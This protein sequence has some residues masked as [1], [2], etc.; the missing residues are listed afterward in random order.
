MWLKKH[1]EQHDYPPFHLLN[2]AGW[3]LILLADTFI[4]SPHLLLNNLPVLVMNS[5][6]WFSGYCISLY[7]RSIYLKYNYSS[8]SIYK[9]ISFVLIVSFLS[10]LLLFFV[11]HL[12][13]VPYNLN[14]LNKFIDYVFTIRV[15]ANNLTRFLPL[16]TTWSLLYFGLKFWIDLQTIRNRA[17]KSDLLA[18]SAQLQML[19]Y[20][21]NPHFLFNSFSSLRALIR[22][23]SS[24]AEEMLT[25]L[26]D[27]YRYTLITRNSNF[28]PLKDE[29]E[30]IKHYA[31]IEKIRFE[32]RI[33][34][35]FA[36]HENAK[37]IFVP[38]FI[39]HPLIENAVKHGK[40]EKGKPLVINVKSALVDDWLVL[41]VENTGTWSARETT[42]PKSGTG[43]GISN[44]LKRLENSYGSSFSF[45]TYDEDDMAKVELKIKRAKN[46]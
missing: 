8:Q 35:N 44:L 26:S 20:Q 29:I 10:S 25:Q 42:K 1:I 2:A 17:E 38:T 18:Q 15:I 33:E 43:T 27:F 46:E 6:Q 23:N 34:F 4:V 7:M 3:I 31:A 39:I 16:L 9:V 28:V 14:N 19:R 11:V 13:A 32:D 22:T 12:I 37:E 45:S 30:A 24:K 41:L 5:V 21:I 36:I 40:S